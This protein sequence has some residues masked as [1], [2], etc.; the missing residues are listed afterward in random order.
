MGP[1]DV[2]AALRHVLGR[3][4]VE[5]AAVVLADETVTWPAGTVEA[6]GTTGLLVPIDND[7]ALHC[8]GCEEGCLVTPTWR[9][10]PDGRARL[11][12]PCHRPREIGLVEFDPARLRR[13]RV[14]LDRFAAWLAGA[15]R[16]VGQ[17]TVL[18]PGERWRLGERTIGGARRTVIL[19][20]SSGEP[21]VEPGAVLLTLA[22]ASRPAIPVASL[23]VIRGGGLALDDASVT[24]AKTYK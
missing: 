9:R 2:I 24:V 18:T 14:D 7:R 22:D 19:A 21:P 10:P 5:P 6:I 12:H 13:W 17:A 16:V 3:A 4:S 8:D 11:V 1:I 20:R 15:A 23:M